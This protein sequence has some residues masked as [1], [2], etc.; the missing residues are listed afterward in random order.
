MEQEVKRTDAN[1]EHLQ[2]CNIKLSVLLQQ[3]EDLSSAIDQLLADIKAGQKYMK[4]YKQM[5]MYNDPA[6]NPIL[7]K[8]KK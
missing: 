3:C 4:T 7:Y 6:L 2:K 5:K 8:N 1:P